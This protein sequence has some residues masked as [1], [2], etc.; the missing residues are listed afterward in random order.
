MM[1]V[2]ANNEKK[3]RYDKLETCHAFDV[4]LYNY[5]ISA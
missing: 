1:K 4:I 2:R 3:E 5:I